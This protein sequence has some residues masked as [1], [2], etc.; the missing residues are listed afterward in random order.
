[1]TTCKTCRTC[2]RIREKLNENAIFGEQPIQCREY[3]PEGDE[4][5]AIIIDSY[6][7]DGPTDCE[8]WLGDSTA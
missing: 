6:E 5:Y 4:G 3:K 2:N 8:N 7:L 1:M